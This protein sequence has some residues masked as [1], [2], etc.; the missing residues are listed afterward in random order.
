MSQADLF[1]EADAVPA[2][3]AAPHRRLRQPRTIAGR[4]F[5]RLTDL[6]VPPACLACRERVGD[7]DT[8]CP[9]C[10]R[11]IAFIRPP[12][13]DRLGIPMPFDPGSPTIVSVGAM[14]NPPA[15]DRARA[16]ATFG[17]LM[18]RLV[19]GFK[20]SDSHVARHLF[21]GWLRLAGDELLHDADLLVPIPLNRWRLVARRFNQAAILAND[22]ARE[23]GVP[24]DPLVLVRTRRTPS[25]VG[26]TI[27][28]RKLNVRGAFAVPGP[29]RGAVADRRIVIVDDV[30]TT[31][32][33]ISAAAR[34]L[35][36]AGAKRVDVLALAL[37]TDTSRI[38]L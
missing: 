29:K 35:R 26:L 17:P 6:V 1:N 5:E 21:A 13:C 3:R 18:R 22:L 2:T 33:T 36:R 32:A 30:I 38:N 31:G 8:L 16:V 15:Y 28:E 4:I 25:Q 10:W 34:A 24:A 37:V 23:T 7:R 11:D 27:E 20:Y 12:L 14:A 19:H 9:T